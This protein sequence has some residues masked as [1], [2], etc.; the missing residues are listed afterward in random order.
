MEHGNTKQRT[1]EAEFR[2]GMIRKYVPLGLIVIV[3]GLWMMGMASDA[4][5]KY[6]RGSVPLRDLYGTE[7]VNEKYVSFD[8][9]YVLDA[10]M[11]S[12]RTRRGFRSESSVYYLVLNEELGVVAVRVPAK[13]EE[14]MDQ[15]MDETWD[16]LNDV[17]SEPPKGMHMEG[18][19]KKL[20]EDGKKYYDLAMDRFDLEKEEE[21]YY[22]WAGML[23]NQSLTGAI[24]MTGFG[25]A[26]MI[27]GL[28][29]LVIMM[30]KNHVKAVKAFLDSHMD[31]SRERLEEDFQKARKISGTFWLGED[32]SY[33]I[34]DSPVIL[35][36]QELEK[37]WYRVQRTGR[38]A[39]EEL[40]CTMMDGKEYS[41]AMNKKK[42]DEA[43]ALYQKR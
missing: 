18:T 31:V 19:M 42:A 12:Y 11:E 38:T 22:F 28:F 35:K 37:A 6:Y 43:K 30:K 15:I 21:V 3:L 32:F 29:I 36:N 1:V 40:V 2:K 25:A 24:A 34:S 8:I 27:L 14:Q 26:M 5:I 13:M 4:L 16:Y 17:R 41:F 20:D 10:F 39:R 33:G 7:Q 23:D 9:D